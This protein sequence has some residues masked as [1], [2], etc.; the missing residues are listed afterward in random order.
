MNLKDYTGKLNEHESYLKML[1]KIEKQCKYIEIVIISGRKLEDNHITNK[2]KND[3]ELIT[4][5]SEWWGTK[6][7]C[8]NILVKIKATKEL[9]NYLRK[10][11]TFCKYYF[12]KKYDPDF[13]GYTD[14]QENTDFGYDDIAF[15]DK[16]NNILL[17]T[18][19]HECY[20]MVKED[21]IL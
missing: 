11:E 16:S 12:C 5:V 13:E 14:I 18:T 7:S 9:F 15:Y 10:F 21:L 17:C 6:T 19:T 8:K 20:I 4:T 3:I 1:D 2:F